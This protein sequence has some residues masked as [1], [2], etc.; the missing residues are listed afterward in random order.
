VDRSC[1]GDWNKER[2]RQTRAD[3]AISAQYRLLTRSRLLPVTAYR[4]PPVAARV[5]NL[6]AGG[7][8]LLVWE[9]LL[10]YSVLSVLLQLPGYPEPV[11]SL[12]EVRHRQDLLHGATHPYAVGLEFLSISNQDTSRVAHFVQNAKLS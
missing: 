9:R 3:I 6:S 2:R 5:K 12:A 8:L 10:Q 1:D 7:A 4:E 11:R